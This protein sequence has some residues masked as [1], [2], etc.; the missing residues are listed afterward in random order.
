MKRWLV[1][2][3]KTG[4]KF[5]YIPASTQ[6]EA[7]KILA[8]EK[9]CVAVNVVWEERTI[10]FSDQWIV[11]EV[12]IKNNPLQNL[13]N[14]GVSKHIYW[15]WDDYTGARAI[16]AR[17]DYS[18][19]GVF[20]FSGKQKIGELENFFFLPTVTKP[21]LLRKKEDRHWYWTGWVYES[22][23]GKWLEVRNLITDKRGWVKEDGTVGLQKTL[24][25]Q[26]FGSVNKV[27]T[28]IDNTFQKIVQ[29]TQ[30][31]IFGKPDENGNRG[32]GFWDNLKS[33]AWA[34]V[35]F[36]AIVTINKLSS[37]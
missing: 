22:V 1:F 20:D 12:G 16:S 4:K 25:E 37:K 18:N 5:G 19:V 14:I 13:Q 36:G 2:D 9:R 35:A 26:I 27:I 23:S 30:D 15:V 17:K 33:I 7:E 32:G 29:S 28:Q 11:Y 8:Q 10:G 31:F 34:F 6:K 21:A 24:L 3:I